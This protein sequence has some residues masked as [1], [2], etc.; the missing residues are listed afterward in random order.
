M[1]IISLAAFSFI[2]QLPNVFMD[3]VKHISLASRL[4]MYLIIKFYECI[5]LNILCFRKFSGLTNDSSKACWPKST[6]WMS[7]CPM[8]AN[9]EMIEFIYWTSSKVVISDRDIEIELG[10]FFLTLMF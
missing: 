6:V 9:F 10:L 1:G 2:V 4:L 8:L 5:V 7:I 3:L